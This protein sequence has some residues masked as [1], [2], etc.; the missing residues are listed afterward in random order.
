MSPA[1]VNGAC[2]MPDKSN[3]AASQPPRKHIRRN[4]A[5]AV[6]VIVVIIILL[7]LRSCMSKPVAVVPFDYFQAKATELRNDPGKII[8]FVRDDL[9]TLDYR[10]DARG[11]LG[12]LWNG[13]ASPEEKLALANALLAAAGAGKTASLDDV[14]PKRD[15]A[16]D[17]PPALTLTIVHRIELENGD[18][19]DT[20]VYDGPAGAL[21]GDVHSVEAVDEKTRRLTLR[22]TTVPT[23][24][25]TTRPAAAPVQVA[26]PADAVGE[27][28]LFTWR[29]PGAADDAPPSTTIRELWHRD[30]RTGARCA[31]AGDRHDFVVIPCRIG[32]YVREKEE[33]LLKQRGRDN[34]AE[35]R[36][37]L[38]LLDYAL[39]SDHHLLTLEKRL[40]VTAQLYEP[41][42]LVL[43]RFV[44]PDLR[45]KLAYALDLRIDRA[46]FT[47]ASPAMAADKVGATAP[48]R[49][50]Q[51]RSFFESSLEHQFL[52]NF[53]KLPA[54]ATMEIFA[55]MKDDEPSC[56]GRRIAQVEAALKSLQDEGSPT[57]V[58]TFAVAPPRKGKEAS[59]AKVA[60]TFDSGG[61]HVNGQPILK[62]VA[63]N[64]AKDA[65]AP[66][67]PAGGSG[68]FADVDQAAAAVEAALLAADVKPGV[69]LT[70][71]M[72]TTIQ[73]PGQS[74]LCD[75]ARLHWKWGSGDATT[76]QR[77]RIRVSYPMLW[78]DWRVQTGLLP[79]AGK[80]K[81][82]ADALESAT[83]HN[84]WYIAGATDQERE[85]SL[86][87]SR[88]VYQSI[89]SGKSIDLSIEREYKATDDPK[90]SRP[91]EF[92]AP[93]T[94]VGPGTVTV[95]VNGRPEPLPILRCTLR[96]QPLAILDDP[97]Y[98]LGMADA[99]QSVTTAV[100]CR[101]V[102]EHDLPIGGVEV[103][104]I[105]VAG[106]AEVRGRAVTTAPDG[107]F[108]LPPPTASDAYQKLALEVTYA[109]QSQERIEVEIKTPG[110]S[111]MPIK[112]H[113]PQVQ[114]VYITQDNTAPLDSLKVSD[115]V[116]RQAHRDLAAGRMVVIPDRFVSDGI[117]QYI[118]YYAC[119]S[120]TGDYNGVTE[121]G[122][123]GASNW[124]Q[125]IHIE[126]EEA[127]KAL[128]QAVE[129]PYKTGTSTPIHAMR[130]AIV[131]WWAYCTYRLE[132]DS[133]E[134]AIKDT[135]DFI[136]AWADLMDIPGT[137]GKVTNEKLGD[138]AGELLNSSAVMNMN[139]D[140]ERV[141][142]KLG[143]TAAALY[144]ADSLG[145]E[146]E[147]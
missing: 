96:G 76:D 137:F 22:P 38:G 135:L 102:D 139:G 56:A 74:I 92:T 66:H 140:A 55:L 138:K 39:D 57:N 114:L 98:P 17:N 31:N 26:V 69:P 121:E 134:E 127:L 144:L 141:A 8:A 99:L 115:E 85:T 145:A 73:R 91:V 136:D 125:Q 75:G 94:P 82:G 5:I 131:A 51:V 54:N 84:P 111:T 32:K 64:L 40:K 24:G 89:K 90:A 147:Y 34:A 126:H 48:Y 60:V 12:A 103:V 44:A 9:P 7:L 58:A 133:A 41:R 28:L 77:V 142:F 49:A 112:A 119:D 70:Y 71:H 101:L 30:N 4:V 46:D 146:D 20:P 86:V 68:V 80:R 52:Q 123:C 16:A 50:A 10:G 81:V 104:P 118:A 130:G 15:K 47:V 27:D 122:L 14:A 62:T 117:D 25:P 106:D 19:K 120:T 29:K 13:A 113:R 37:Y 45:G 72:N 116:K 109:D 88:A 35:A 59:P 63:D 97:L 107:F 78:Y 23:I 132:G 124:A 128:K 42:V 143:Y 61:F 105:E 43:S 108:R 11:A 6:V 87:V 21:V 3:P 1:R 65:D 129:D 33:V 83:V 18:N 36:A 2:H 53:S 110:L 79:A 93:L 67:L 95:D 100:N